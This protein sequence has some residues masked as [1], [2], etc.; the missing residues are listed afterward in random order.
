VS[1]PASHPDEAARVGLTSVDALLETARAQLDMDIAF[2][3]EFVGDQRVMRH[4][5][6]RVPIVTV[7]GASEPLDGTY[8]KQIVDGRLPSVIPDSAANPVAAAM[9][10]TETSRIAAY[11]GVPIVFRDGELYGTLCTVNR[12]AAP[13]LRERDASV[14]HVLA[15]AVSELIE[16]DRRRR[17]DDDGIRTL[18]T[19]LLALGGPQMVYQPI[20]EVPTR[21][22]VGYEALSRFPTDSGLTTEEWYRKSAEVGAE[23]EL[24]L[25]AARRAVEG[26]DLVDGYVSVNLRARR[27]LTTAALDFLEAQPV[28]RLVLEL[29][30]HAA[31]DDYTVLTGMLAPL[32]ADGLRVAVDD[33]GAGYASLRHVLLLGADLI[34]L[35]RSLVSDLASD[36]VRHALVAAL[37]RF[38]DDTGSRVVAEGVET[39]EELAALEHL[40]VH[41][42]Q[43]YLLGRPA[44]LDG[45]SGTQ[46]VEAATRTAG[47]VPAH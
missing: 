33:T 9:P 21:R 40:G 11:V 8:C 45:V 43:G 1:W 32:R 23:T 27:L 44:P 31:V 25:C 18:V 38:A 17:S 29:T 37:T 19:D 15:K 12:T 5:T 20:V 16:D 22:V 30:E 4:I 42:V 6:A 39:T 47:R 26:L 34:K 46:A 3:S 14:L 7:P 13:D 41:Y 28:D 36:P 24:E 10:T 35:D 2:V